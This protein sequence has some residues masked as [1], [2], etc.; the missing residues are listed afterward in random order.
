MNNKYKMVCEILSVVSEI[1]ISRASANNLKKFG[2][3]EKF[4]KSMALKGQ[5]VVVV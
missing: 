2:N 5:H 3:W 1:T 4:I